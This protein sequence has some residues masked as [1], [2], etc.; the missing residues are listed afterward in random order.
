MIMEYIGHVEEK[1]LYICGECGATVKTSSNTDI[2]CCCDNDLIQGMK[3]IGG[4][5]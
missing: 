3:K 4:R 2:E 1:G 5:N